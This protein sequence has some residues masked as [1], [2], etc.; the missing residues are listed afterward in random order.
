MV[1]EKEVPVTATVE[2]GQ[3]EYVVAN[4]RLRAF[5]AEVTRIR[6]EHDDPRQILAAIRPHF[7]DLLGDKSWLPAQYQEPA[8]AGGMGSG[9]GTWLLYRAGDGGLAL[10]AL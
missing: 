1:S 10:S 8:A 9:I 3:D 2:S 7:A 5:V 4:P 6:H